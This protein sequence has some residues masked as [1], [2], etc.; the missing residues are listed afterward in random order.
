MSLCEC[1]RSISHLTFD[2]NLSASLLTKFSH[3]KAILRWDEWYTPPPALFALPLHWT[4]SLVPAPVTT[5]LAQEMWDAYVRE[6]ARWRG[7]S[8]W[9]TMSFC[10]H[11]F[12]TLASRRFF[13]NLL[14]C[15]A[16]WRMCIVIL[17]TRVPLT[18]LI[19]IFKTREN[20]P[21]ITYYSCANWFPT[22]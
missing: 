2:L 16:G 6:C 12:R 7:G 19:I 22:V 1:T 20:A 11:F 10:N 3:G 18:T 8:Y 15:C 9:A 4:H 17:F 14:L 5:A 13:L 21:I